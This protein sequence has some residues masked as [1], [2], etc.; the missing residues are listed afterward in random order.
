LA[1]F[2]H[3][4]QHWIDTLAMAFVGIR[5]AFVLAYLGNW[6][7]TR[8]LLWNLGFAVNAALF[9]MPLWVAPT[10]G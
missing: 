6:P 4:P 7:T 3:Q 2:R 9:F 1:E 8:T 5:V 10:M